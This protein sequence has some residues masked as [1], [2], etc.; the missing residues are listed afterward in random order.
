MDAG[1]MLVPQHRPPLVSLTGVLGLV[2]AVLDVSG[3]RLLL[4]HR[5]W[6]HAAIRQPMPV[7]TAAETERKPLWCGGLSSRARTVTHHV[8][9]LTASETTVSVSGGLTAS[10]CGPLHRTRAPRVTDLAA[11]ITAQVDRRCGCH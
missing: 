2:T 10:A 4:V 7:P 6:K 11:V 5:D 3:M 1:S 8:P 9:G